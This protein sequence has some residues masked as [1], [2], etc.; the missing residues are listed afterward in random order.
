MQQWAVDNN[1][2]ASTKSNTEQ[3]MQKG[4][5]KEITQLWINST[6]HH[7]AGTGSYKMGLV[8]RHAIW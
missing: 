8:Q 6:V 3:H 4:V 2:E 1:S 5:Q 7:V